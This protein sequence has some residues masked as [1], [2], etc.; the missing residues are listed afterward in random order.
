MKDLERELKSIPPA[1]PD[2]RHER[3]MDRLFLESERRRTWYRRPIPLWQG[4]AACLL[5]VVFGYLY[6]GKQ[7]VAP[8][9]P[10]ETTRTVYIVPATPEFQ[11]A[12]QGAVQSHP[13][14]AER[15]NYVIE[16]SPSTLGRESRTGDSI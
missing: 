15:G 16:V 11:R 2:A 4:L 13:A 8:P 5:A 7:D 6:G 3:R 1:S 9:T 14:P 12:V 10:V